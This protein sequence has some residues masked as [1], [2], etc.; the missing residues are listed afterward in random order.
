MTPNTTAAVINVTL[1]Q[2]DSDII[3]REPNFGEINSTFLAISAGAVLDPSGNRLNEI[4]P[5]QPLNVSAPAIDITPP[6]L[7]TFNLDLNTGLLDLKFDEVIDTT[8]VVVSS[9][10]LQDAATAETETYSLSSST[11]D[12]SNTTLASEIRI[13]LSSHDLN[14]IKSR[15]SI[16]QSPYLRIMMGAVMD[17]EGNRILD[18]IPTEVTLLIQDTT[19][20][21]L[22][23]FELDLNMGSLSLTFSEALNTST[24][25]IGSLLLQ[26]TPNAMVGITYQ[27]T[28]STPVDAIDSTLTISLSDSDLD[29]IKLREVFRD[30][31]FVSFTPAFA[32]DLAGLSVEPVQNVSARPALSITADSTPPELLGFVL[33]LNDGKLDLTFNEPVNVSAIDFTGLTLLPGANDPDRVTL[34]GGQANATSNREVS[35]YVTPSDLDSIKIIDILGRLPATTFISVRQGA[36]VDIGGTGIDARPISD[37]LGADATFPD[38]SSPELLAFDF[39]MDDGVLPLYIL[40]YFNEVVDPTTL[41]LSLLTLST[42]PND[43]TISTDLSGNTIVTSGPSPTVRV[44]IDRIDSIRSLA[45]L[46]ESEST[47][48]LI[49]QA[50][51]IIDVKNNA[52]DG[53]GLVL[54]VSNFTADLVRPSLDRFTFD[55]NEGSIFLTFS[56]DIVVESFNVSG[57]L[58][59]GDPVTAEPALRLSNPNVSNKLPNITCLMLSD[60][61]LNEIKSVR[62]LYTKA[63][64]TY[65][66]LSE[67][68]VMDRAENLA[69]PVQNLPVS[70]FIADTTQPQLVNFSLSLDTAEIILTFS[71]TVSAAS[72][73]PGDVVLRSQP[74]DPAMTYP[75]LSRADPITNSPIIRVALIEEDVN[76]LRSIDGL[77]T[78]PENTFLQLR[79]NAIQDTSGNPVVPVVLEVGTFTLDTTSPRILEFELDLNNE[80]LILSFDEFVNVSSLVVQEITLQASS[81]SPLV[82]YT[83]TSDNGVSI[84]GR[85]LTINLHPN[86]LNAI[87][88]LPLCSSGNDCFLTYTN[89]T[90]M[91][92]V[93][94]SVVGRPSEDTLSISNY[95]RDST[96]PTLEAFTSFDLETGEIVLKFSE[97]INI[98]SVNLENVRL[99]SLFEMPLRSYNLTG[100]DSQLNADGTELTINLNEE[101]L[102][103][104]K[105][106][107]T[108]CTIRATC[109]FVASE[110]FLVDLS[111]NQFQRI[112][113]TFPG[114]IVRSLIADV[115]GPVLQTF[116]F[117][118][119]TNTLTLHFNEPV[120]VSTLQFTSLTL[121]SSRNISDSDSVYTLTGGSTTSGDAEDIIVEL[122]ARDVIALKL[123]NGTSSMNTTRHSIHSKK[124]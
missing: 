25:D 74:A 45:P 22:Q 65:I 41:E 90:I 104:V 114:F 3:K 24:V 105:S 15:Q 46:G 83:L 69:T 97:A 11:V 5:D 67:G 64:T 120:D 36:I 21:E 58:L 77:A 100:G 93:G 44:D 78:S 7:N 112:I 38:R 108:L 6:E 99:Q 47:I 17:S 89:D 56:E 39:R 23:N 27:L 16:V 68:I 87:K 96:S 116:D 95:T 29:E 103:F 60:D 12:P 59:H 55:L 123:S 91:D 70:L 32:E 40:L 109:Y 50:N 107:D 57:L 85:V 26:S 53:S 33:N 94:L 110:D 121:H 124:C 82:N 75:L 71:E 43:T 37:P 54:E 4:D 88:L 14:Q 8:M 30:D 73:Q 102:N 34:T 113:E 13:R 49:A 35:V 117:N 119:N 10:I 98:S 118:L 111:G 92:S 80:R 51:V 20:P 62:N 81:S 18:T 76:N 106:E 2:V 84:Q 42:Q 122:L 19:E 61:D 1:L 72:L 63:N 28:N 66:K 52:F 31:V 9:F 115:T 86:D 79:M 101:D 48:Y